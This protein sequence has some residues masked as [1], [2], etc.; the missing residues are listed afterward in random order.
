M[1]VIISPWVCGFFWEGGPEGKGGYGRHHVIT[2][3]EGMGGKE[4]NKGARAGLDRAGER[5]DLSLLL[6]G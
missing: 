4:D 6:C 5:V 2:P 1:G 3:C